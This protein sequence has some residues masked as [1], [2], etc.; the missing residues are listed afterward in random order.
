MSPRTTRPDS[1]FVF[2]RLA[3]LERALAGDR[4]GGATSASNLEELRRQLQ[5]ALR[6]VAH[7]RRALEEV[8]AQPGYDA[9]AG[10]R[11]VELARAA[12]DAAGP[13]RGA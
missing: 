1:L 6:E 11:A 3:A 2:E 9:R 13:D 7:L 5:G 8:A 4:D 12:L 10:R